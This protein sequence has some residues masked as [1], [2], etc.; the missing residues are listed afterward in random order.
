MTDS[1]ACFGVIALL[2]VLQFAPDIIR[3][4]KGTK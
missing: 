4:W 2:A 3:A 1:I